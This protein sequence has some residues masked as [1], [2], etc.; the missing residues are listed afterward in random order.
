MKLRVLPRGV[1]LYPRPGETPE[2]KA[3][4]LDRSWSAFRVVCAD[5][6]LFGLMPYNGERYERETFRSPPLDPRTGERRAP[7]VRRRRH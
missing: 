6:R 5:L 4:W 3:E 7:K 1:G 2:Q